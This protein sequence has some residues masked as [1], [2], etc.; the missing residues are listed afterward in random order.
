MYTKRIV[1]MRYCLKYHYNAANDFLFGLSFYE[2]L[3]LY[4][5]KYRNGGMNGDTNN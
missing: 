2:M 4:L 3:L 1:Q 5:Q